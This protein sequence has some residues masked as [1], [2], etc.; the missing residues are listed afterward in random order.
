MNTSL[1]DKEVQS[2]IHSF[3]GNLSDLAFKGSPFPMIS[4]QELLEQIDGFKRSSKK[5][6]TWVNSSGILYPPKL[7]LEQ[8]SSEITAL[9]KSRLATGTSI[10]DLTGGFGVDTF[11]FSKVIDKVMYFEQNTTLAAIAAHNFKIL[12]A[13]AIHCNNGDGLMKIKDLE[14]D[15]IYLDPARR[16][17]QKG[18]VF[19]FADCS[20]NIVENLD[21]LLERAKLLLI[22]SSPML[23]IMEGLRELRKVVQIHVIAV[24]NEVKE[25]LWVLKESDEPLTIFTAN[26]GISEPQFYSFKWDRH[27]ITN[28]STPKRFLYEP[29][30]ALMKAGAY[31]HLGNDF[32]LDKISKNAHLFTSNEYID[33][34]GRQFEIIETRYY[35]KG[36]LKDFKRK[37]A[38]ISTR[39]F[40]E[41]VSQLRSKWKIFDGG[42]IYLFFTKLENGEKVVLIT[43][44]R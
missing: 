38:H 31:M 8:T 26:L 25:V 27:S 39:D 36:V 42:E 11:F 32:S 15:T 19:R 9:Y 20:P 6:P 40:P 1:L 16:D 5:L 7:N 13:D 37:K 12:G 41:T 44:K 3:D 2:F 24:Q 28:Y 29:N 35:R 23:D 30:A 34:P 33:F 21:Y 4:T 14:F 18:K 22:K 10:A 17:V 43:R